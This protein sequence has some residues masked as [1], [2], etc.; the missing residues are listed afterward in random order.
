MASVT[1]PLRDWHKATIVRRRE[2][3]VGW[4]L[5]VCAL[6]IS[7]PIVMS[8]QAPYDDEGYVMMTLR[9]FGEGQPLYS[10]THTQYGPDYYFLTESI[11]S[12]LGL[13]LSQNG[14]RLKTI[15]FW[16]I[17]TVLCYAILIRLNVAEP[18][19]FTTTLLF[20]LHLD[21]LSLE[22]GQPQEWILVLSLLAIWLG[23]S[24]SKGRWVMV[25]GCVAL[26]GMIKLNCGAVL[27]IPLIAEALAAMRSGTIGTGDATGCVSKRDKVALLLVV[28]T[29][30]IVAAMILLLTVMAGTSWNAL[31]WGLVGQRQRFTTDFYYTIPFSR[32][33]ILF[34]TVSLLLLA[35]KFRVHRV[36]IA[37]ARGYCICRRRLV[38]SR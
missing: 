5:L 23:S 29:C 22:P 6:L 2:T 25:A 18:I 14:V 33:G 15:A 17:A 28:G 21:K 30:A 27:A 9:T 20:H 34:A 4:F 19:R 7:F 13:P 11:H 16:S 31:A 26:V 37:W 24:S 38:Q 1:K 32:F 3:L 36:R 12:V 35:P 10:N 8:T